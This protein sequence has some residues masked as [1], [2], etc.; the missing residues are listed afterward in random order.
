MACGVGARGGGEG[1]RRLGGRPG[2]EPRCRLGL[3]LGPMPSVPGIAPGRCSTP[4]DASP[5]DA[6]LTPN[7][8]V[9]RRKRATRGGKSAQRTACA[10]TFFGGLGAGIRTAGRRHGCAWRTLHRPGGGAASHTLRRFPA[11]RG[12]VSGKPDHPIYEAA[13]EGMVA[14]CVRA[15]CGYL[16]PTC[17]L[18]WSASQ[19]AVRGSVVAGCML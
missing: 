19:S 8:R 5:T 16:P 10:A 9:F 17:I 15:R 18:C 6:S 3:A 2:S 14:G 11:M 7:P 1:R 4:A 13:R 12:A